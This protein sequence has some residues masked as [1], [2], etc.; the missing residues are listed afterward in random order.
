MSNLLFM[1]CCW[2]ELTCI[3]SD[4]LFSECVLVCGDCNECECLLVEWKIIVCISV[5]HDKTFYINNKLPATLHRT[6]LPKGIKCKVFLEEKEALL[7]G[8]Q[9]LDLAAQLWCLWV[10]HGWG[11]D[12]GLALL[13]NSLLII[14]NLNYEKDCRNY[15][16]AASAIG[17]IWILTAEKYALKNFIFH[18]YSMLTRQKINS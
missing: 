10:G 18:L 7:L 16:K 5:W 9:F 4:L 11:K 6:S 13:K 14:P 8:N 15:K 17:I 1:I 2:Q 3:F 12:W